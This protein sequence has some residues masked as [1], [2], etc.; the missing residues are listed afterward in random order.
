MTHP[1]R[2]IIDPRRRHSHVIAARN[3]RGR[4]LACTMLGLAALVG[5]ACSSAAPSPDQWTASYVEPPERVWVAISQTLEALGYDI[6]EADRHNSIVVA[7]SAGDEAEPAVVLRV[8]QVA[9][10]EV[11]R[12]HVSPHG[13][14]PADD[15]FDAAAKEFLAAL[16]ATFT[17]APRAKESS[18]S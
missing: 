10:T 1:D 13:G 3:H 8:A 2:S 11:I 4:A 9:R 18:E 12:V 15:R 7:R 16:D 17:G 14:T 5:L 6:E